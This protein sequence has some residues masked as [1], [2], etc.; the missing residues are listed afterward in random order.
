M[1]NQ[2]R[3]KGLVI[4]III[5]AISTLIL[6]GFIIHDKMFSNNNSNSGTNNNAENKSKNKTYKIEKIKVETLND[7]EEFTIKTDELNIKFELK[8]T[9]Y[10]LS[11]NDVIISD[12]ITW[13][14]SEIYEVDD[15]LIFKVTT[16]NDVGLSKIFITSKKGVIIKTISWEDELLDTNYKSMNIDTLSLENNKLIIKG[17]RLWHGPSIKMEDESY[18]SPCELPDNEIIE[19]TYEIKY[20][21]NKKFKITNTN[22]DYLKNYEF[23]TLCN[24]VK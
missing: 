12:E 20:L 11:I 23:R 4:L 21:G 10:Q 3:N 7:E 22:Y 5:F 14:V 9:Y 17:S 6:G 8:D 2:K 13:P 15:Y 18:K 1:E 19:G 16:G 24:T